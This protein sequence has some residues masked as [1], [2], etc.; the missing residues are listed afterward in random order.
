MN[1]LFSAKLQARGP[2]WLHYLTATIFKLSL[3]LQTNSEQCSLT[4]RRSQVGFLNPT[5]QQHLG[6]VPAS[7]AVTLSV[8]EV[9]VVVVGNGW[10]LS[11][12]FFLQLGMRRSGPPLMPTQKRTDTLDVGA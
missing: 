1:F 7:M 4:P 8:G 5:N 2:G 12:P 9:V 6:A 3:N 11:H 10:M